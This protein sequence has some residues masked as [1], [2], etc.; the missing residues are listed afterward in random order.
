MREGGYHSVSS[1]NH[2]RYS[3]PVVIAHQKEKPSIAQMVLHDLNEIFSIV[4]VRKI[5]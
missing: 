4:I 5:N 3:L 1:F 2:I